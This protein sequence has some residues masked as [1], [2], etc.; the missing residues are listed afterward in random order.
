MAAAKRAHRTED[1][2]AVVLDAVERAEM[3][4]RHASLDDL[5][6]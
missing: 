2:S 5:M 4:P 3:D 6:P 1:A